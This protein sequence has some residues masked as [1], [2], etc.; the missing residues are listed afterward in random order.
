M[1]GC[2]SVGRNGG[3]PG[4]GLSSAIPVTKAFAEA[5]FAG[6]PARVRVT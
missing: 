3:S 4:R 6:L 2:A 1:T 5:P